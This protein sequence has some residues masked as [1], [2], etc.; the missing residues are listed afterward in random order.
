[1][2]YL[3]K[4]KFYII[5]FFIFMSI[6]NLQIMTMENR[7]N[8]LYEGIGKANI[9]GTVTSEKDE[10]TYNNKYTLKVNSINSKKEFKGTNLIIYVSKTCELKYGDKISLTGEY[11]KPKEARNYKEF[12]YREYLKSKFVFGII[13]AE[14][15]EKI[16]SNNLNPI[17]MCINDVRES[18][19]INLRKIL[20]EKAEIAIRNITP[21]TL[22]N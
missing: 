19:K 22:L 4:Y 18:I 13:R 14:K 7:F 17:M 20:G 21:V 10:S 1:M 6:S 16:S 8:H 5:T 15:V 3:K 2:Y 11:E 12:N 9:I